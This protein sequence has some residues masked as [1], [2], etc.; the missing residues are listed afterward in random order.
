MDDMKWKLCCAD[1]VII[2]KI[3]GDIDQLICSVSPDLLT[4]T[5][6]DDVIT[7]KR[8]CIMGPLWGLL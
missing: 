3:T 8:F 1:C 4:S 5:L 6:H 2:R 7:W